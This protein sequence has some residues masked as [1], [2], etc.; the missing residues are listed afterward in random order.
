MEYL[1]VPVANGIFPRPDGGIVEGIFLDPVL[2]GILDR[3]KEEEEFLLCAYSSDREDLY[4]V[5]VLVNM[6]DSWPQEVCFSD[7][8]Q[9]TVG[10]FVR[11]EGRS[12]V[13]AQGFSMG[14]GEVIAFGCEPLDLDDLDRRG[15]SIIIGFGWKALGG[16]TEP[17]GPKEVEVT[18]YG[19]DL[20]TGDEVSISAQIGDLVSFESAHSIEHAIIRS[21]DQF[22]LCTPK[23]LSESLKRETRELAESIEAGLRFKLP[24]VFGI[25]EGGVCGNPMTNLAQ[26]YLNQEM[27]ERLREGQS[28]PRSLEESRKKALSRL[29]GELGLSSDPRYRKLQGL[30]KGMAHDPRSPRRKLAGKILARFPASPWD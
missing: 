29:T 23:T 10:Q 15:Y 20:E 19:Q 5:G 7:S 17:R 8:D 21:L 28:L 9:K 4:S 16:F 27:A 18:V 2:I 24:E 1:T 14:N 25:T 3:L 11:L 30:K 6:L 26:L 22:G 13:K 12:I